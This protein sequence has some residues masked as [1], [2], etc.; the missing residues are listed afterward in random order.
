LFPRHD[1]TVRN[2]QEPLAIY[3]IEDVQALGIEQTA[4]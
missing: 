4:K 3:V 1:L 2:R